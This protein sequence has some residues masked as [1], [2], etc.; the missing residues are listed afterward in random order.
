MLGPPILSFVIWR[1]LNR[2]EHG[3]GGPLLH[4]IS[5]PTL[6]TSPL[7]V[8]VRGHDLLCMPRNSEVTHTADLCLA[9]LCL[10][11]ADFCA[12]RAKR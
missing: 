1:S 7:K 5:R 12:A 10:L 9:D 4:G 6:G 3:S 11:P 2:C 8:H